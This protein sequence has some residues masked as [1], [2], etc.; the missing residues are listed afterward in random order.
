MTQVRVLLRDKDLRGRMEEEDAEA[1]TT[2][3]DTADA[4]SD[5]DDAH[6]S[7]AYDEKLAE[8]R[9]AASAILVTYGVSI[10]ESE[11]G[12]GAGGYS[13]EEIDLSEHDEL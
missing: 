8:V 9:E 11:G 4:W 1:L 3:L 6:D 12:G 13:P 10:D 5:S 2:L 7:P